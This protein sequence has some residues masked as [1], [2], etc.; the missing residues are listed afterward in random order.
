LQL[1]AAEYVANS[2]SLN[3]EIFAE[4]LTIAGWPP[5]EAA[6]QIEYNLNEWPVPREL[7][8]FGQA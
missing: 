3:V 8:P 5:G 6:E 1:H 4:R 2:T 7:C